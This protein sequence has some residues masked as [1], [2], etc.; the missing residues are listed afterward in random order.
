MTILIKKMKVI[1]L[2]LI[3]QFKFENNK[4]ISYFGTATPK[5]LEDVN[6]VD[7]DG[8]QYYKTEFK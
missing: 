5:Q 1:T 2:I 7:E 3:K 8:N 6:A 4:V